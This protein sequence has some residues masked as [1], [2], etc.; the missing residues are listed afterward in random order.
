MSI[1]LAIETSV[2]NASIAL[3]KN[4]V[5]IATQEFESHRKQNQ[6]LFPALQIILPELADSRSDLI[7]VGTGPSSY[8]GSRISIAAAQGLGIAYSCPVVGLCSYLATPSILK[9]GTGYAVGD[10]RRGSFFI[11]SLNSNNADFSAD[12]MDESTFIEKS[13]ALDAPLIC[14]ED[15]L[16]IAN[17]RQEIPHA[18]GLIDAWL[19]LEESEQ[20]K[21]KVLPPQPQYLRAPFIT[22]A[23]PGH[24]LLRQ[25]K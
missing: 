7:I 3:S 23:N 14:F 9:S 1:I 10:A 2:A 13:S 21:L 12:L 4:G 5:I 17:I 16:P 19:K 20:D 6:L 25:K 22:K 11:A 24:P 18:E 15:T 8:S